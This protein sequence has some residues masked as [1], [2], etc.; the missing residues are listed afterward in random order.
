MH[1][2]QLRSWRSFLYIVHHWQDLIIS[3][4]NISYGLLDG[5][6]ERNPTRKKAHRLNAR[7]LTDG[8]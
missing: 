6:K 5:L 7:Q 2:G 3:L 8:R 4:L 1:R